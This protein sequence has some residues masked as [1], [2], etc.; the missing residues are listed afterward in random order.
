MGYTS[1]AG[2]LP[3]KNVSFSYIITNG[4]NKQNIHQYLLEKIVPIIAQNTPDTN[5][6]VECQMKSQAKEIIFPNF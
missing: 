6:I 2:Y 4:F 1:L 5:S 3:C